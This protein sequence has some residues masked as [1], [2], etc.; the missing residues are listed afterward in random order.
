MIV[1]AGL[2]PA[3]QQILVFDAVAVGEVNRAREVNWCASGKVLNVARALNS[4]GADVDTVCPVGGQA[5]ESIRAEF[6]ADEIPAQWI[7]TAS[8]TR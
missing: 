8:A 2:S 6:A 1:A 7:T 5:G 4:L 3:W